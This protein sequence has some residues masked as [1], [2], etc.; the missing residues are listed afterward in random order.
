LLHGQ[1]DTFLGKWRMLS[2]SLVPRR[3][4]SIRRT[5]GSHELLFLVEQQ[6]FSGLCRGR[7]MTYSLTVY[8]ALIF[9]RHYLRA[10]FAC[11]FHL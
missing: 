4:F 10:A 7:V 2:V 6:G 9:S 1:G 5:T 8:S 3:A 11:Y